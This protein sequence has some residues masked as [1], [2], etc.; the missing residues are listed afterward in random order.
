MSSDTKGSTGERWAAVPGHD[1][2]EVSDLGRVRE[3]GR[4]RREALRAEVR[5]RV[6]P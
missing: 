3:A 4:V 6:E 5:R 1:D 2:Y